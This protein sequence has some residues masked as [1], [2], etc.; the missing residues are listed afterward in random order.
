M[1]MP[2]ASPSARVCS[3]WRRSR[4][5][6]AEPTADGTTLYTVDLGAGTTATITGVAE[7]DALVALD[8]RPSD[9][10]L[11]ALSGSGVVYRVDP[12]SGAATV[13]ASALDAALE[14]AAIGVDSTPTVDRCGVVACVR[15]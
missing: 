1:A 11:V 8:V 7:G 4:R 15:S 9:R 14:A 13:V 10:S 12:T 5:A 2:A 3:P 6:S